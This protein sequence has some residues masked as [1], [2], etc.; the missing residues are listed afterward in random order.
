[1]SVKSSSHLKGPEGAA[2]KST[3][4]NKQPTAP[5]FP[6]KGNLPKPRWRDALS[7][8]M[9]PAVRVHNYRNLRTAILYDALCDYDCGKPS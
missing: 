7:A 6:C 8:L 4:Q 3:R 2:M 5:L 1:M 9:R